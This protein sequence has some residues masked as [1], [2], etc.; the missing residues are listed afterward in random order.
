[1]TRA[2]REIESVPS[3]ARGKPL[4][5][6]VV[7]L[8]V[9]GVRSRIAM[10]VRDGT[11]APVVFLHGFGSTKEDYA[12]LALH[13]AFEDRLLVAFDMPGFGDSECSVPA[14]L[15]IPFLREVASRIITQGGWKRVHVVGHSM[16]G[17]TALLLAHDAPQ[18]VLSFSNIEGNLAPEDCF[19]SR[20]IL[21]APED[22]PDAFL[23]AFLDRVWGTP[24]Y[25]HALYAAGVRSKVRVDAVAPVF[26]S[27]VALADRGDLL[28]RF[29]RLPIPKA[30]VY[31]A[32]NASLSYLPALRDQG[33]PLEEIPHSGHF[34]MYANPPALWACLGKTIA[35]GEEERHAD[36]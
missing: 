34:P 17:L 20:Q 22:R 7:D 23:T 24:A 14:V 10:L 32:Q 29:V 3:P 6:R 31:G 9:H 33:V 18:R 5:R 12:D 28:D 27:I 1:M 19:F 11:R 15:T 25:S 36:T 13:P 2:P 26:R 8:T 21:T 4:T 35:R 30:F 16:G